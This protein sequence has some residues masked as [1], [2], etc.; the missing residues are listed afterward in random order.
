[1]H[2][3]TQLA[4][5]CSCR[6]LPTQ[7]AHW[8]FTSARA[9]RAATAQ[10]PR[11]TT[12]S[13]RWHPSRVW[14]LP[15]MSVFQFETNDTPERFK[16]LQIC[17]S[18]CSRAAEVVES[19]AALCNHH[20]QDTPSGC[21]SA[22]CSVFIIVFR[23]RHRQTFPI[24]QAAVRLSRCAIEGK[25]GVQQQRRLWSTVL[26]S[27]LQPSNSVFIYTWARD[28]GNARTCHRGTVGPKFRVILFVA[29]DEEVVYV[30]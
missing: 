10:Q 19:A 28:G 9:A 24:M 6:L 14:Q 8:Q 18:K 29:R 1:M 16:K 11:A 13:A 23:C 26:Q 25:T 2:T 27:Q 30:I 17:I 15:V 4:T 7:L 5:S 22:T 21:N 12:Y 20:S 3:R